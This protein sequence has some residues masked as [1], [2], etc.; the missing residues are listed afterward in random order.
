MDLRQIRYFVSVADLRSIAKASAHLSVAGPA[1]SRSISALEVELGCALFDRDGRGMQLTSA[2]NLLYAGAS[3]ILREV[4]LVRQEVMAEGAHVAGEVIIGA[5]PSVIAMA[6]AALLR[7]C[8]EHLPRVKPRLIEGYSAYLQ[9]WTLTSDVDLALVNGLQPDNARLA[10]DC[11]AVERLFAIGPTG[12][13]SPGDTIA[14]PTLLG[15]PLILPSSLNPVRDLIDAA[16]TAVGLKVAIVHETDSVSLLKDLVGEGLSLAVL[17]FGAV[18]REIEMGTLTA[19]PIVEPEVRSELNLIYLVDRPPTRV[20]KEVI[21]LI[22]GTL[23][24]TMA[25]AP[26]HGFVEVRGRRGR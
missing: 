12:R 5:T 26:L 9:N 22:V 17:P 23:R 11:I 21:D 4:E 15:D 3:R 1:I 19:C 7:E 13:F 24:Q 8:R 18:K 20:A 25:T 6:G 10:S 2:G 16:A 14:L